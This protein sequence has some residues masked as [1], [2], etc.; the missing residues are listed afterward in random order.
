VTG[1]SGSGKTTVGTALAE[2]LGVPFLDADELH[3]PG[4]IAKMRA[5]TPL[6]DTD[7]WPWLDRAGA[8]LAEHD[9]TGA[10][11][12]C[13]ALRRDYRDRL[14]RQAPHTRFVELTVG[15]RVLEARLATR[16][17]AFM[18]GSLLDSQLATFEPL[19]PDEP[20]V[21]VDADQPVARIVAAAAASLG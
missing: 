10:V 12:A 19:T 18:P 20:G 21:A 11:L 13:S 15:H 2:A 16:R 1:V 3:S 17:H 14:L 6:D 8:W 5:G 7:R 9:D 4:S